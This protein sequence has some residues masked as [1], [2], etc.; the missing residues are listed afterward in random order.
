MTMRKGKFIKA[1]GVLLALALALSPAAC[2]KKNGGGSTPAADGYTLWGVAATEK[3]LA[4]VDVAQYA[5]VSRAAALT[6]DAAKNDNE[7]AQLMI[8]AVG[9]DKTYTVKKADL[10]LSDGTVYSADNVEVYNMKYVTVTA[11][12]TQGA[13]PSRYPDC[14]LPMDKAVEYGENTVKAGENASLFF[15]FYVP[16]EQKEGTYTGTFTV[17]VDGKDEAIPV[18]LKVRSVTVSSTVHAKSCVRNDFFSYIGEYDD[19]QKMRDEYIKFLMEYRLMPWKMIVDTSHKQADAE[20]YAQKAY[21]LG[22]GE[23]CSTLFLPLQKS[24]KI[25]AGQMLMYVTEFMKQSLLHGVNLLAKTYIYGPDE[26]VANNDL[27]GCTQV[28]QDFLSQRKE[29]V[30]AFGAA[31][32]KSELIGVYGDALTEMGLDPD[33]FYDECVNA[34]A[35]IGMVTTQKWTPDYSSNIDIYCPT[36]DGLEQGLATGVY[37]DTARNGGYTEERLWTYGALNPR[38]PYPSY[39]IDAP[40]LGARVLGWLQSIYNVEGNLY[41]ASA[42]YAHRDSGGY[43]Y[44]DEYYEDPY[45]YREIP[46]DGYLLYP[47]ARYGIYGPIPSLRLYSIRDG[48]E[49]YEL[50]YSLKERY[51]EAGE[52]IGQDL[53]ATQVIT[54]VA[55]ELYS[56]MRVTADSETFEQAREA[57]LDLCEFTDSG[58]AFTLADDN[59]EGLFTWSVYVPSGVEV[60]VDGAVVT[61][62]RSIAGGKIVDFEADM[63]KDGAKEIAS[64][65]ATKDGVGKTVSF[66]LSG[67]VSKIS[68]E[69]FEG[70]ISGDLDTEKSVAVDGSQFGV[71]GKV[72]RL[73]L[74]AAGTNAKQSVIISAGAFTGAI[75]AGTEKAVLHLYYDGDEPLDVALSA[76]YG[77]KTYPS[78]IGMQ[79]TLT[80]G[81]NSIE[82]NVGQNNWESLG[83]LEYLLVE[84]GKAGDPAREDVYL[85]ELVI[86]SERRGN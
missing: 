70:K 57:L 46:G 52:A 60:T 62:E 15:S 22:G 58:V 34:I 29:C 20:Y 26:P 9:K 84:V 39:H 11:T 25:P 78:E 54:S 67:K 47:G 42:Y 12:W 44:I 27:A 40:L 14:L 19:T 66:A 68:P 1:V 45:R 32:K 50:M 81:M 16:E 51:A 5:S 21:E 41:W 82:W 49:E 63:T 76:K 86:Y 59:G 31:A 56:G 38:A 74:K 8:S 64:F 75:A 10:A 17:T 37:E 65:T 24:G 73:S 72:L 48:Y 53:D 85:G 30:D 36:F 69:T 13:R 28:Y 79:I 6:V 7:A 61:G 3:V 23:N 71:S 55:A 83:E 2:A 77:K 35:K 33:E 43:V 4:D 18:T 80:R